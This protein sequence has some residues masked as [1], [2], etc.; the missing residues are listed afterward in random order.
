MR[1]TPESE[2]VAARNYPPLPLLQDDSLI[3]ESPDQRLLTK[4]Y[5]EAAVS[6]IRKNKNDPF[7]LYLPHTFPHIPLYA[8][9]DF[10][11][12]SARGLY[13][14]VVQELDWSVGQILDAMRDLDIGAHTLVIFTSDNGPWL[15]MDEEGGSA[16]LL[17]EGKGSTWE[18]GMREPTIAWWP[19]TI[20]P[21]QTTQ[22]LATS[23]DIFAT[24]SELSGVDMPDDRIMDGTSLMPI[25]QDASAEIRDEVYYYLGA[26][27]FA[28]RKGPWK[29]HYKT[30]TPYRGEQPVA[31]DPP[32]LFHLLLDPSEQRNVAE[33]HPDV[34][35]ML[36]A[37]ALEHQNEFVP[38]PSVLEQVD[39]GLFYGSRSYPAFY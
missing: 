33:A 7:L 9:P 3:E 39:T 20:A 18:G 30:L 17:R 4:R 21:G 24:I 14:D 5:T 27:L 38:P 35:E 36:N 10:E 32:Q 1:P 15:V 29:L 37:V 8:S 13:G 31:H 23:M 2:W 25:F 12:K 11:G 19:G 22:S 26:E 28:V 6:F 34:I 16:G